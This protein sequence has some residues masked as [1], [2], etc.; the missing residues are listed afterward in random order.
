MRRL[1]LVSSSRDTLAPRQY[2]VVVRRALGT[3]TIS[4]AR[5]FIEQVFWTKEQHGYGLRTDLLAATFEPH[6]TWLKA[7]EKVLPGLL[8]VLSEA[9]R[10]ILEVGGR[11][12]GLM[13]IDAY[14]TQPRSE[15]K[16]RG[17][18]G[19]RD[20]G[21]GTPKPQVYLSGLRAAAPRGPADDAANP[22]TCFF[23]L[24]RS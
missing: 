23:L 8:E 1:R 16:Q 6:I 9:E 14:L 20:M 12:A 2:Y 4:S 21:G 24:S 15:Y 11:T 10:S 7:N 5:R 13:R 18:Q 17:G 19:G 3:L 22:T